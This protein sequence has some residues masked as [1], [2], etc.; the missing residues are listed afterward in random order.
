VAANSPGLR[1]SVRDGETGILVPFGDD[2]AL[3]AAFERV[4]TDPAQRDAL[5]AA[6][7]RW[8]ARFTW[9][10]CGRRSLDAL[11]LDEADAVRTDSGRAVPGGAGPAPREAT[12]GRT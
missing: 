11:R 2:G 4:L 3:A 5:A 12:G 8:A 1:D 6:G 9:P 7:V 10:E